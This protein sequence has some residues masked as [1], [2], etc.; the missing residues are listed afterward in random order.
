[1]LAEEGTLEILVVNDGVGRFWQPMLFA[2]MVRQAVVFTYLRCCNCALH[3]GESAGEKGE[4]GREIER[5][6]E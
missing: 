3:C 1:M 5:K 6:E 4:A 2:L